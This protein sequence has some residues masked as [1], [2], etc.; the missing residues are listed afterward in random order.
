MAGEPLE[1]RSFGTLI[2]D[3]VSVLTTPRQHHLFSD[4]DLPPNYEPWEVA[5]MSDRLIA[6]V[7]FNRPLTTVYQYLVP[8]GQRDLIGPG[9]RV[10]A[11]FGRGDKSTDG[12]CVGLGTTLPVGRTLKTLEAVLDRETLIDP[13]MMDL[14]QWIADRYL[15]GWGQVLESVIPKGVKTNAGTRNVTFFQL[16]DPLRE[17]FRLLPFESPAAVSLEAVQAQQ[18]SVLSQLKLPAKQKVVIEILVAANRPVAVDELATAAQCGVSPIHA[19]CEKGFIIPL[20]ERILALPAEGIIEPHREIVLNMDQSRAVRSILEVVRSSQ[21]R[22]LLLHGVTGSGKTEVYIRAIQEIVSYGR[23]AIVLVPEISLTPQTIRRFRSR[24]AS[25]AV[26][27]SHLTDAERHS[28]W[29]QIASGA[30]QVVVGARS[31]VFAPTPNLGMIVIDEEH[32]TS[33]KQDNTP[34]YHAR[35]VARQRAIIEKIP[36]ILGSAEVPEHMRGVVRAMLGA[37]TLLAVLGVRY[38]V[39]MIPLLM[40]EFAWKCIWVAAFGLPLWSA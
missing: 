25:V 27:H 22:T 10:V 29:K 16:S 32:E 11:P 23:Q 1:L 14:T 4:E 12:Y 38:P 20:R 31:A 7:V 26:L 39:T 28:H 5:A 2:G 34:R 15:C 35:E 19:L 8:D 40:F 9:K 3:G 13:Q 18:Q 24:F 30:V 36:L 37:L 6:D 21:H 33:F 17:Q